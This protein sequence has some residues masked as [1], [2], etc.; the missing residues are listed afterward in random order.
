LTPI[1]GQ[2]RDTLTSIEGKLGKMEDSDRQFDRDNI[3]ISS[4]VRGAITR[5]SAVER[6]VDKL[7]TTVGT[8]KD[9][10]TGISTKVAVIAGSAL[11]VLNIVVTLVVFVIKSAIESGMGAP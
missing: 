9:N 11:I 6:S 5:L 8:L 3:K 7:K 10:Q 4:E 2:L 1:V